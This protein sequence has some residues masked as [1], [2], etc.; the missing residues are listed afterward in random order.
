MYTVD[1]LERNIQYHVLV[2][3]NPDKSAKLAVGFLDHGNI[4][5]SVKR[6]I[7]KVEAERFEKVYD[8][9]IDSVISWNLKEWNRDNAPES[10]K[11]EFGDDERRNGNGLEPNS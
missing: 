4:A 6:A 5:D 1:A 7:E 11:E 9:T 2:K 8:G 10:F 3:L